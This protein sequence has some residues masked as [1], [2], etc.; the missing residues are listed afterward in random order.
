MRDEDGNEQGPLR[1]WIEGEQ[2]PGLAISRSIGDI[3]ARS[4]GVTWKPEIAIYKLCPEDRIICL[5]TDGIWEV[6]ENQDVSS[7]CLLL[8]VAS[9][10]LDSPF[11]SFFRRLE[12]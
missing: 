11:L 4:I 9:R 2:V 8:L 5:A 6:L 7:K 10:R 3:V 12:F 1:I